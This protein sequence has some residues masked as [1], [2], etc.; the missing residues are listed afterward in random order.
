MSHVAKHLQFDELFV[1]SDLHFGGEAGFQIFASTAEFVALVEHVANLASERKAALVIN[2]DFIDFLAEQPHEHFSPDNAVA[3]LDRV[4]ADATFAPIFAALRALLKTPNRV[5]LI[6]LGNHDLELALPWVQQHLFERLSG[7]DDAARGRIYCVMDGTG[8]RCRVANADA[9]ILHGN[10]FDEW[11]ATD[12]HQFRTLTRDLQ[13]GK[14]VDAWLPS[15][16]ARMVIEVMNKIKKQYPFVDLLKPEI[17]GVAKVLGFVDASFSKEL[18]AIAAFQAR[19][20]KDAIRMKMDLLNVSVA[21]A[22]APIAGEK[23][24]AFASED[25]FLDQLDNIPDQGNSAADMLGFFSA[26]QAKIGQKNPAEVLR[27]A[28]DGLAMDQSFEL[29]EKDST[30]QR[31]TARISSEIAFVITGHT[32]FLRAIARPHGAYFNSGTW[33]RLIEVRPEQSKNE[34]SFQPIFQVLSATTLAELDR[35]QGE[36]AVKVVQKRCPV[37]HL[38]EAHGR[39]L[40]ELKQVQAGV[41]VMIENTRFQ[42][43]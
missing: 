14:N 10:E 15:A 1:V 29:T 34:A 16:G 6:N 9:L 41:L 40:A 25:A 26:I 35:I 11:N 4:C 37:V 31:A 42:G 43:S 17:A 7:V 5:L 33:A 13:F 3:K 39:C 32:H 18:T 28:L 22:G 30:Y 20:L 23:G 2:G 8:L 19:A 36:N 21:G 38:Y 12:Y 24:L 27:L